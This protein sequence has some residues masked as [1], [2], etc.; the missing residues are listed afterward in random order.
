ME[1]LDAKIVPSKEWS[2]KAIAMCKDILKEAAFTI[3]EIND[4]C[5]HQYDFGS[6]SVQTFNGDYK[7]LSKCLKYLRMAIECDHFDFGK[8]AVNHARYV[9]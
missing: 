4:R 5:S 6:L 1:T 3:F 9:G 7:D 8:Y 2:K